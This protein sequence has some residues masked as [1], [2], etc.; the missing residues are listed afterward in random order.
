MKKYILLIFLSVFTMPL[1]AMNTE[2]KL[3]KL[4][5]YYKIMHYQRKAFASKDDRLF[6]LCACICLKS[7]VESKELVD[8]T[9]ELLPAERGN[10]IIKKLEENCAKEIDNMDSFPK[11]KEAVLLLVLSSLEK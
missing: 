6:T 11:K 4:W 2:E 9:K 3:I 8:L 1:L 7:E 10:E 5:G